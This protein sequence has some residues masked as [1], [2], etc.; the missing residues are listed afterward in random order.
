MRKNVRAGPGAERA[1]RVE[2]RLVERLERRDRTADVERARDVRDGEDDR[3]LREA[4]RD[5]E[6]LERAAEQPEAPEGGEQREPGHRRRQD[7]RQLDQ[8]DRERATAE[9]PVAMKY[10]VGVPTS[11]DERL[12]DR[13]R[14]ERDDERVDRDARSELRDELTR[15]AR[16]GRSRRAEAGGT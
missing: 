16:A 7:E 12:R 1:R 14:L 10:A 2:Q 6:R 11:E 8:R 3:R 15:A 13:V 5:A 4:H 9:P